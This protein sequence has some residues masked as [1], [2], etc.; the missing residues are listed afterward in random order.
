MGTTSQAELNFDAGAE[1]R[2]AFDDG[3]LFLLRSTINCRY[4]GHIDLIHVMS[5]SAGGEIRGYARE[6]GSNKPWKI[7]TPNYL[8]AWPE[9]DAEI[10]RLTGGEVQS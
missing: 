8:G 1:V 4:D 9:L 3:R 2:R 6:H 5:K 7:R 10:G